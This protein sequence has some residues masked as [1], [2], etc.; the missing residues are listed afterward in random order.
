MNI[1]IADDDPLVRH[2]LKTSLQKW[3]HGVVVCEDGLQ[4]WQAFQEDDAPKIAILD[5]MMPGMEGPTICNYLRQLPSS[6]MV[7]VIF[8]SSRDSKEDIVKA[9]GSGANDFITKPV[10]QEELRVHLHI[11]IEVVNL[12]ERVAELEK[13]LANEQAARNRLSKHVNQKNP[14]PWIDDED[15]KTPDKK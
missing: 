13:S 15:S 8:L 12:R 1:L 4:A 2:L 5:W 11:G 7:Y 9:L 14:Y 10:T 6:K 3:G